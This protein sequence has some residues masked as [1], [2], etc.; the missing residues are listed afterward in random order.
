MG[1]VVLDTVEQNFSSC[2]PLAVERVPNSSGS[3]VLIANCT[4]R[5]TLGDLITRTDIARD[6]NEIVG[7]TGQTWQ[8]RDLLAADNLRYFLACRVDGCA[9]FSDHSNGLFCAC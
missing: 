5:A 3:S 4:G 8:L 9:A 2:R 7:I 6:R 1:I